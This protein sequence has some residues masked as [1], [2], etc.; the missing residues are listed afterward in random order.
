MITAFC[1]VRQSC[2]GVFDGFVVESFLL[3]DQQIQMVQHE[4]EVG[5]EPSGRNTGGVHRGQKSSPAR[6]EDVCHVA[7]H[8]KPFEME[9]PSTALCIV[10]GDENVQIDF[11]DQDWFS[12]DRA[13][14][15]WFHHD[16]CASQATLARCSRRDNVDTS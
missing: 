14:A 13:L 2:D 16:N 8:L 11:T 4:V 12:Y 9:A 6:L 1:Q 5:I 10:R 7:G 15:K 3:D